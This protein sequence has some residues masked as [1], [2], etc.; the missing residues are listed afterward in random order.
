MMP[1]LRRCSRKAV[2]SFAFTCLVLLT[3]EEASADIPQLQAGAERGSARKQIE[4]GM[5]YLL[6]RGVQ[7]NE[8]Q[9][10]YWYEKAASAGD[11]LAQQEI[12]YFYQAGIGVARDPAR[13]AHW[14]QL[15]AAGGLPA[16]KVNLG[17]AYLWGLGVSKNEPLA[18]QL[19]HEAFDKHC[20]TAAGYLGEAYFLGVGV[21]KDLPTAAHWFA[22]G[23][24]MHDPHSEFRLGGLASSAT[25]QQNLPK[26]AAL[27][28]NASSAGYVPAKHALG[29][30]IANHPELGAAHNEAIAMLEE[31]AEAGTWKSS[32]ALGALARDGRGMPVDPKAAYLHFKIAQMQGGAEAERAVAPDLAKLSHELPA[33]EMDALNSQASAWSAQHS[34]QLDFVYQGEAKT[35]A[36]TAP[37]HQIHAGRLMPNPD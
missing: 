25:E 12:G 37:D 20:G 35:L 24:K 6:G 29:L 14:F 33:Q 28:R 17:V 8:Q 3:S 31:S 7:R 18:L 30:L 19:F 15:A 9:A 23:A 2:L 27:L 16:A 26:A 13:A 11:P 21:P 36:L 32:A 5:D 4:L 34:V 10:A 1:L 22:L